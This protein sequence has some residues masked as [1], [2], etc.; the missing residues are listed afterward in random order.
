MAGF[1]N[2]IGS[3][4]SPER[5][6]MGVDYSG[7][8]NLFAL[9]SGTITS[10]YNSGWPG[11]TF[12][13][14]HLDAG[15]IVYYAE[16][17]TPHVRVGDR[18]QPGSL[19]GVATGG[20]SGIEIGWAAP[21]GTGNA[22]AAVSGQAAKGLSQGDPG[23]YSTGYGVSMSNLIKSLGGPAG[24]I[25]PGGVQGNVP[26]ITGVPATGA[27]SSLSSSLPAGCVPGSSLIVLTW[28]L[29]RRQNVAIH[30]A[31]VRR[32]YPRRAR[33]RT[34]RNTLRVQTSRKIHASY[35]ASDDATQ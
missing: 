20:S 17:I 4:L 19:I 1:V 27:S 7:R 18:V 32:R 22:M 29:L 28:S 10:I 8:G 31:S 6:D 9:G 30:R 12:I 25:Q 34:M 33:R 26:T 2:P 15:P 11:G 14:L 3:G 5:I 24:V 35:H 13:G 21:P 23:K 16:D